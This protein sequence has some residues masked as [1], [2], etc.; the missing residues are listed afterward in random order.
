MLTVVVIVLLLRFFSSV[1]VFSL[2]HCQ[3]CP[4]PVKDPWSWEDEPVEFA[5]LALAKPEHRSHIQHHLEEVLETISAMERKGNRLQEEHLSIQESETIAEEIDEATHIL[6]YKIDH[7]R[8]YGGKLSVGCTKSE[9][10][11]SQSN[12]SI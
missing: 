3:G 9:T 2:I 7:C 1:V 11:C 10:H 12:D 5:S 8:R 6:Q 4:V